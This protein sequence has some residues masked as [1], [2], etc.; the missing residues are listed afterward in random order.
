M[1]WRG[2]ETPG[3]FPTLGYEVAGFIEARCVVPDGDLAGQRYELTDEMLRFLLWF[4]R[5]DPETGRFVYHRGG[6]LVRPQKWGKSPLAAAL[7]CAEAQG[8]VLADGWD[9]AG[10]PVGRPWPTP[11]IQ[12]TASSED[13]TDNVWDALLPMIELGALKAFIPDTGLTRINLPGG[14]RIE[15]VTSSARSRL[16]QRVTFAAQDQTESWTEH[17]GGRKLADTQRRNLA[18]TKGRFLET[19]NAWDPLDESV[20]QQTAE[21]GEPGV[22]RDD[23]DPGVGSIRNK[24]ERRRMLRRVYGDSWWIDFERIEAEM[25]A[26]MGRDPAQAER[27]FLNRKRAEEGAAFD[28]ER[29]RKRVQPQTVPEK[30]LIVIGVDGARSDDALGIVATDVD[31]GHQ[32]VVGIWEVPEAERRNDEYEHPLDDVDQAMVDTFETYDVWRVYID[33]QYIEVLVDRWQGRWGDKRILQWRT[34]RPRAIGAACRNYN[35]AINR[36]ELTH[37]GHDVMTSHIRNARRVKLNVFE[38]GTV[39]PMW[40][41]S[42]DRP[43][44]PRKIDGAMAGVLSWEARG[45]AIA[46]GAEKQKSGRAVFL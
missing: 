5:L 27:F 42:K 43:F 23:V 19:C 44:S 41:I 14:G 15:A 7:I 45:D 21:A 1:P 30:N 10:E 31:S 39:R 36:A 16:G 8:P 28:L 40:T 9:A 38:E 22:Y 26:L 11:L 33:P 2:P 29:W 37:D 35:T 4:Y 13:Q 34:N 20:A 3:E 12:V 18:G 25:E 6:Q 46:A 24:R 17:N 32:F